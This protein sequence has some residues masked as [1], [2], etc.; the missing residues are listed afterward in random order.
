M[1]R[2]L[3]A[4][5][6]IGLSMGCASEQGLYGE[7]APE[8]GDEPDASTS[9]LP[10]SVA[11]GGVEGRVCAPDGET[12]LSLATVTVF[13]D[14]GNVTGLTDGDG[15]FTVDAVPVG[16]WPIV[17]EKGS[18][19]VSH[20]VT[21]REGERT[22]IGAQDCVPLDPG[23]VDIAVVS[24]LYDSVE[25]LLD[26]L[27]ME[28]TMINGRSGSAHV[29][30]LRDPDA[31]ARYDVLFLNC[32]MNEQWRD[33]QAEIAANLKAYV[34]NGGS[35]YASDWSYYLVEATWPARNDFHGDDGRFGDAAVGDP[36]KVDTVLL[37]PAMIQLMGQDTARLNFD[38]GMWVAMS[39]V[40]ADAEVLLEGSYRWSNPYGGGGGQAFGPLATR[41]H[42]G[43][44]TVIFTS[45]HNERQ[46]TAD[47]AMLLQEIVLSL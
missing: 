46:A 25:D 6:A 36:G 30:L 20:E 17:V 38:L 28:Y 11:A 26:V 45:F 24:G 13:T 47:M 31:L 8:R 15:W 33:H 3:T 43:L 12:Y 35:I 5:T 40:G 41:L 22:S 44:G 37:D 21:V 29:N 7:V 19:S 23:S 2:R 39:D 9:S 4:L 16:T 18:F 32:G 27:G 42:D 1:L 14:H 10:P 34:Q